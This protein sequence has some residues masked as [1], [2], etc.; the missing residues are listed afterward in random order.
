ML[1]LPQNQQGEMKKS[2]TTKAWPHHHCSSRFARAWMTTIVAFP[3]KVRS[4]RTCRMMKRLFLAGLKSR[5]A[6]LSCFSLAAGEFVLGSGFPPGPICCDNDLSSSSSP[7]ALIIDREMKQARKTTNR[8]SGEKW[9]PYVR[10]DFAVLPETHGSRSAGMVTC[11]C[12]GVCCV[13]EGV[14]FDTFEFES[15]KNLKNDSKIR[16][17]LAKG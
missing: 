6:D 4:S 1:G 9:W 8:M 10:I 5:F 2:L 17:L 14:V 15:G 7:F 16:E 12:G 11:N 13:V 3:M